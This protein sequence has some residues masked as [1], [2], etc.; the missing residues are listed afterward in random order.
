MSR[1]CKVCSHFRLSEIN[2]EL[3]NKSRTGKSFGEIASGY[4]HLTEDSVKWHYTHHMGGREL[5]CIKTEECS[6]LTGELN[7]P[8]DVLN[9]DEMVGISE[10]QAWQ[11]YQDAVKSG[12]VQTALKSQDMA[13][14]CLQIRHK[15]DDEGRN[16][17]QTVDLAASAEWLELRSKILRALEPFP[18]ARTAL[19]EALA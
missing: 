13:L 18:E 4:E 6:E 14:K 16:A 12:D 1:P 5:K 11:M 9:P 17:D 2:M 19:V 10:A 15:M 3:L 8:C 7:N